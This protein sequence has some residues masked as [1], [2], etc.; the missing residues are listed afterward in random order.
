LSLFH[1][2]QFSSLFPIVTLLSFGSGASFNL[3][4]G[5]RDERTLNKI[6]K[7]FDRVIPDVSEQ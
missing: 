3:V 1:S 5:E 6:E 4:C 2:K 7:H